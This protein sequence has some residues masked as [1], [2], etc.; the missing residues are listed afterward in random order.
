GSS[1]YQKAKIYFQKNGSFE[2]SIPQNIAQ[3]SLA[4]E[5]SSSIADFNNDGIQDILVASGGGES[6][7]KSE[8]LLDRLYLGEKDGSFKR[9]SLLTKTYG[10]ASV[11]RPADYDNDGDLDVFIGVDA[12][13]Y[14]YGAMPK[15]FLLQNNNGKFTIV[16]EDL[17]SKLGMITD[18]VWD[19]FDK[20]GDLDLI[21]VG[22]WTAPKFL[23]N[24]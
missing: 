21:T 11:I 19:D 24:N 16:Q 10:N 9:D 23:Q 4:E 5:T 14:N 6:V 15:S 1:R 3:D 7:G 20:D 2:S 13:N 12:I 18:A 22:E 17:T 8:L